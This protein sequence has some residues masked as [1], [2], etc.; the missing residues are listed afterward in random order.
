VVDVNPWHLL[1]RPKVS[2]SLGW[3]RETV[4]SRGWEFEAWS[5][6]PDAE[7]ANVRFLAGYRRAWLLDPGLLRRSAAPA[8][9]PGVPAVPVSS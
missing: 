2:F 4:E 1:T 6:P 7:L 8:R 9:W 3:A 5:E